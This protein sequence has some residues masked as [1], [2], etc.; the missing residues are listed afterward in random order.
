MNIVLY[1]TKFEASNR[2][3][4]LFVSD[5]TKESRPPRTFDEGEALNAAIKVFWT[6]GYDGASL[7]DLTEAMGI[8]SPSL[9]GAFD[10]KH[11]LFLKTI[12]QYAD[13]GGCPPI[14]ALEAE[15]DITAAVR[16]FLEAAITYASSD[17]GPSG[18]YLSS[19]VVTSAEEVAGVKPLLTATIDKVETRLATRFEA[20]KAAG[21]LPPDFPSQARA[22]LMFDI[23]QGLVY[24]ARA[25]VDLAVMRDGLVDHA[26]MVVG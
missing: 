25:G 23:R 24:R 15:P 6:K 8:N 1:A 5:D 19:S 18:C 22:R 26:R 12:T 21:A 17:D 13:G 7:K 11:S 10:D 4:G 2:I 14:A 16:A 3:Q 20:E 9:Y